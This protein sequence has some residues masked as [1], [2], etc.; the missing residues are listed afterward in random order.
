MKINISDEKIIDAVNNS[1]TMAE[2]NSKLGLHYNTFVRHAKRLGIY[3]PNQAGKG[4]KKPKREGNGKI[5]LEEILNGKYPQYQTFKLKNRLISEGIKENKCE[6]CSIS[7]WNG[8]ILNCELDHINGNSTDHSI[9]NLK[10]LCPNCHSQTETYAGKNKC[11]SIRLKSLEK[12][13]KRQEKVLKDRQ[14]KE[15]LQSERMEFIRNFPKKRGWIM[16]IS[17][18]LN[19]SHTHVR[20]LYNKGE[21]YE[22]KTFKGTKTLGSVV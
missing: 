11:N 10:M 16:E 8:K 18:K 4:K 17:K 15:N 9:S 7:S 2:A 20:R 14:E 13:K 1:I 5:P 19:I 3:S 22:T 21:M 6:E 12:K